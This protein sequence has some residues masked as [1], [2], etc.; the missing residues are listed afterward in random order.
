MAGVDISGIFKPLSHLSGIDAEAVCKENGRT[1]DR[2]QSVFSFSE[3][4]PHLLENYDLF[5]LDTSFQ[6]WKR[7]Q[8]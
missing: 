4:E 6:E 1:G 5:Y 3:Y 7:K 8:G 2:E